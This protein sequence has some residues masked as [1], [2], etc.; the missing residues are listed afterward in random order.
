MPI[1]LPSSWRPAGHFAPRGGTWRMVGAK[2]ADYYS[3]VDREDP[4]LD[5]G[6][7]AMPSS[8]MEGY[9]FDHA[10]QGETSHGAHAGRR[11][12]RGSRRTNNMPGPR[13]APW[14]LGCKDDIIS[15]TCAKR[16]HKA[17]KC[18]SARN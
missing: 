4:Q 7:P 11:T 2:S 14:S 8:A 1:D 17:G 12:R 18:P 9:P 15:R 3:N 16:W 5:Q 13:E 6:A 10:G